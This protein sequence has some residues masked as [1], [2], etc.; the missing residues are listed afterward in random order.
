MTDENEETFEFVID[1][2][3][4]YEMTIDQAIEMHKAMQ[5]GANKMLSQIAVHS[6]MVNMREEFEEANEEKKES[7]IQ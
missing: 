3:N 5:T 6:F 2:D 7:T 1:E 4:K